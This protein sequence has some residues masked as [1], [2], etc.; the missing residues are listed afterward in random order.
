MFNKAYEPKLW[1][2]IAPSLAEHPSIVAAV[3][4]ANVAGEASPS[5]S[6]TAIAEVSIPVVHHL[7][8]KKTPGPPPSTK[9]ALLKEYTYP[10]AS[11]YRFATPFQDEFHYNTENISHTRNLTHLKDKMGGPYFDLETIWEEHTWYE[12]A[13]RSVEHTMSTMVQ[14]P[15]VNHVPTVSESSILHDL[16][17][18]N[19]RHASP[20]QGRR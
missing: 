3:V 9:S 18:Y 19:T 7:A 15:Y 8:G 5:S 1:N 4:Y 10:A 13:D 14:E 2:T 17:R 20:I 16:P 6:E 11:S 12:F